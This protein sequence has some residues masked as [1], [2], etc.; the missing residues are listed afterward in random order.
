LLVVFVLAGAASAFSG[1][2]DVSVNQTRI[3]LNGAD[4]VMKGFIF[5][6]FVEDADQLKQCRQTAEYCERHLQARDF[7]FDRPP[8]AENGGL[9]IARQLEAN[10]IRLNLNQAALDPQSPYHSGAYTNEIVQAVQAARTEGFA[11]VVALFDGRNTNAPEFL[12]MRNPLTPI[13]DETTLRAAKVLANKFGGDPGVVIELLNEPWS[14]AKRDLGWI[15]WRDGGTPGRG[16]FAGKKFVGVNP[17]IAAIRSE[18]AKNVILL[19]GLGASFKGF[20]GGIVDPLKRVAYSVH[21]FLETG[22]PERLD[23]DGNFGRFAASNPFV[24]SAWNNPAKKPWCHRL[25]LKK[26]QEFLEYLDKHRIGLITYALDVPGTI[27]RDFR[28]STTKF[29]AYGATCDE[30][31]AAGEI[32][33]SH[34]SVKPTP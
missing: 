1:I 4:T 13:D 30:G 26:P 3:L 5:Q 11:V 17:V 14:P 34:F 7:Y 33:K 18:G 27:L 8:F 15:Y 24:I 32:I 19:Q 20:P 12:Q 21:P 29:A 22:E 31:G 23:W 2:H 10:T 25:G 9:K 6:V 28:I 16:R